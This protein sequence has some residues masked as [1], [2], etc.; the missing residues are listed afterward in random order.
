VRVRRLWPRSLFP[1]PL[2]GEDARAYRS[3]TKAEERVPDLAEQPITDPAAATDRPR[4]A[5]ERRAAGG[6]VARRRE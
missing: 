4:D 3:Y 6:G 2:T 1:P 5:E